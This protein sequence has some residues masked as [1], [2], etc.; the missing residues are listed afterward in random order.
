M[1]IG[2]IACEV[3]TDAS[4]VFGKWMPCERVLPPMNE[5]VLCLCWDQDA[6]MTMMR[7]DWLPPYV[8]TDMEGPNV[9]PQDVSHWMPLPGGVRSA[10]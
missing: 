1:S 8:W 4:P 9:D 3:A 7:V 10:T 2:P 6:V 5:L